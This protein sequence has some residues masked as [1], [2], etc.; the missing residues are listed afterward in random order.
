MLIKRNFYLFNI[1]G[2]EVHFKYAKN[3]MLHR[4]NLNQN[5]MNVRQMLD[6]NFKKIFS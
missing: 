5:H 2:K 3:I 4:D 1:I 6:S